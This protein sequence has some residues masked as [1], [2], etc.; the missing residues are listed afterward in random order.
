[1][2]DAEGRQLGVLPTDQAIRTAQEVGLDLVEISPTARPPVCKILDYGK[3]KYAEKKRAQQAK[4]KQTVIKLKEVKLRPNTDEHD[5]LVK[6]KHIRRFLE[7]GDKVKVNVVFRGREVAYA[8]RG[9]M[10]MSRILEE[11]KA[12]AKVEQSPRLEGKMMIMVLG[13]L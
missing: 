13:R 5:V 7:E 10:L 1:M 12:Q 4:K 6:V 11:V 2:I 8:D 3:F 9:R